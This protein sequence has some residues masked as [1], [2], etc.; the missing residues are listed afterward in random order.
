MALVLLS[1]LVTVALIIY[2]LTQKGTKRFTRLA[3]IYTILFFGLFSSLFVRNMDWQLLSTSI[4]KSGT[5]V[6]VIEPIEAVVAHA[7]ARESQIKKSVLI[8]APVIKQFPELPRGCEVTSLAMLLQH[9][10]VKIDKM[11]LAKEVKKDPTP[12]KK[13]NGKIYFGNPNFGFV[14]DMYS[15]NNPGFGVYHRPIAVLANVYLPDRIID[16]TGKDFEEVQKHLSDEKPVWVITNVHYKELPSS[17]FQTWHTNDG[18]IDITYKEH[19]VLITGYDEHY[20]YF[21]DPQKGTK[22]KKAPKDDFIKSWVQM[23]RQAITYYD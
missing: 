4:N 18:V 15:F 6:H 14:G 12:Y 10:G 20:I 22:N 5:Q 1:G 9:A 21:N 13:E 2:I 11:T 17:L 19:S 8:D 23:G 3:T 7:E 16:L